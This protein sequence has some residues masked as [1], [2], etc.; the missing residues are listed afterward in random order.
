MSA[1]PSFCVPF[2]FLL[3]FFFV[4]FS[5]TSPLLFSNIFILRFPHSHS[6]LSFY[7]S[8]HNIDNGAPVEMQCYSLPI[9]NFHLIQYN[10]SWWSVQLTLFYAPF[11][12]PLCFTAPYQYTT[13]LNLRP[14]IFEIMLPDW[15]GSITLTPTYSIIP[16]GKC[17]FY[18][19]PHFQE[20]KYCMEQDSGVVKWN[21]IEGRGG[22]WK[23]WTAKFSEYCE[24]KW[25]TFCKRTATEN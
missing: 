4:F 11:F 21:K 25:V 1:Y 6:C 15:L 7:F 2:L 20:H 17:I 13:L 9:Q 14:L 12:T 8:D 3:F 16:H 19:R 24:Q 10:L 18:L 23:N 22:R 5:F